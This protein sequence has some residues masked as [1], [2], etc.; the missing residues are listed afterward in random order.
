VCDGLFPPTEGEQDSPVL[1]VRC[2]FLR[3]GFEERAENLLGRLEL[4]MPPQLAPVFEAGGVVRRVRGESL[5]ELGG[6]PLEV[7][8]AERPQRRQV[9]L[10][11]LTRHPGVHVGR[12]DARRSPLADAN[13]RPLTQ[14]DADS[15]SGRLVSY[16]RIDGDVL[17]R[18]LEPLGL[19]AL[20]G[21]LALA[22][23]GEP[24]LPFGPGVGL[25]D[26]PVLRQAQQSHADLGHAAAATEPYPPLDLVL[27]G[28]RRLAVDGRRQK[29][30]EREGGEAG[31]VHITSSAGERGR[32]K[33]GSAGTR[34]GRPFVCRRAA[35]RS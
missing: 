34:T 23:V 10:D 27:A 7:I 28:P 13:G 22:H 12:G 21:I 11:R 30:E 20:D 9:V 24:E 15:E 35:A 18:R 2:D 32:I 25:G 6:G 8:L 1:H 26:G 19:E 17:E 3:S 16:H 33:S 5:L 4:L 14:L 29:E 31:S